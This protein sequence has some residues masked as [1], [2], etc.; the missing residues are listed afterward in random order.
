M[1][2][3]LFCWLLCCL[4]IWLLLMHSFV[5][6]DQSLVLKWFLKWCIHIIGSKI[7]FLAT[8][9]LLWSSNVSQ[10]MP[11]L[12][13]SYTPNVSQCIPT[14]ATVGLQLCSQCIPMYASDDPRG[15]AARGRRHQW[16]VRCRWRTQIISPSQFM[17]FTRAADLTL[18][19]LHRFVVAPKRSARKLSIG[20]NL[21]P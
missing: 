17:C 20:H 16:L 14:Y 19:Q 3:F 10:R 13:S 7:T 11:Q 5:A 8:R 15:E 4:V 21:S 9:R 6:L 18:L 2:G 1:F 12:V